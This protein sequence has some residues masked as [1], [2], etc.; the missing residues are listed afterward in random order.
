MLCDVIFIN[1][2]KIAMLGSEYKQQKE[3]AHWQIGIYQET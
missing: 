3:K 2:P 1:N